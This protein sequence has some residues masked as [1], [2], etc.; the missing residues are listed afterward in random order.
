MTKGCILFPLIETTSRPLY[1]GA[2]W[3][4]PAISRIVGARS[5]IVANVDV[6]PPFRSGGSIPTGHFARKGTR[7]PRF[8]GVGFEEAGGGGGG[9]GPAGAVPD[10]GVA[11]P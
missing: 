4:A 6:M 1:V 7:T 9:L 5:M 3:F 11:V 10:E 2:G 8:G